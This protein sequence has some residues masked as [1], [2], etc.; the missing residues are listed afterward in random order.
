MCA[1]CMHADAWATA[2]MVL[3]PERGRALAEREGLAA[4]FVLREGDELREVMV[5]F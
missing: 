2:L 5:G 1:S 4:I 3:G